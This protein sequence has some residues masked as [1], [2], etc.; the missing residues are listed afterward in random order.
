MGKA[1][2]SPHKFYGFGQALAKN[3]LLWLILAINIFFLVNLAQPKLANQNLSQGNNSIYI[4]MSR[5]LSHFRSEIDYNELHAVCREQRRP[6]PFVYN[7]QYVLSP[8]YKL[9]TF[10]TSDFLSSTFDFPKR[11]LVVANSSLYSNDRARLSIDR[12]IQDIGQ[13]FGCQVILVTAAGG[14][15]EDLKAL[16]QYEYYLSGLDGVV[17]IGQLPAAWFEVPNDHYWWQGGYGYADWICDLFLMD[18]DG[19][20]F[21]QDANG[22]YDAH[23]DGN[24]DIEAEIFVGRIDTSTMGYYGEEIDLFCQYMEKNHN[25]WSGKLEP[26]RLGLVYS[27]HDWSQYS[28][29][30]FRH[31]YGL[32][33]YEDLKWK[34]PPENQVEKWDYLNQRLPFA[35]YGF[36]QVWTHATF[37]YHQFYTGGICYEREVR[38]KRPRALG[39]NLIGCH[40]C[41]W[42]AGR[43]RYFL[44]GSYIYNDSPS[45]LAVVGST[46]VGGMLEHEAFYKSLG[47]NNCLGKAFIDWFNERLSSTEERGYIIGWHYG[48]VII[49]D[50]LISFI[51]VPGFD[52]RQDL[53]YPPSNFSVSRK[54]NRSLLM[55]EQIDILKWGQN[56]ANNFKNVVGYRLY[57]VGLAELL[58]L[59]NVDANTFQYFSRQ[60]DESPKRYAI[61][62]VDAQGQESP[63]LFRQV[64]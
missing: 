47:K 12:Y 32:E 50:P 33:D 51:G 10:K 7:Y 24:G 5:I 44:G 27:D 21:D 16:I 4:E 40:G 46:K 36:I 64:K 31:L 39:Y 52:N 56:I 58:T 41:D 55:K 11:I 57:R 15:V 8:G 54:E 42:A 35:F 38:E 43:G 26:Y 23:G 2:Q 62:T 6:Y 9:S 34:E 17:L 29:A 45:S 59:A 19:L 13:A 28:S 18:L 1:G 30:Y 49:G 14:K 20:W 25:Y 61:A 60:G 37:E 53:P 3:K 63:L 48:M 22:K